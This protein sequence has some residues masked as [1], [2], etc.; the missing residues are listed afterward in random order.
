[1]ADGAIESANIVGYQDIVVP[2]GYS[3]FTVTFKKTSAAAYSYD[4]KDIQVLNSA[5]EVM[6]DDNSTTPTRRSRNKVI[7]QKMNPTTGGLYGD[8]SYKF[9]TQ[10]SKGWCDGS[11]PLGDGELTFQDGEGFAVTCPQGDSIKFR[12]SGEVVLT[13]ISMAIPNGYSI[14]G[15]M[16]PNTVDVKDIKVL[17]SAGIEMNDDSS[18]T[19][20]QRSRNKIIIQKMNPT[21]GGLYGD[22]SY[23]FNTQSNKGWCDGSTPLNAGDL[24]LAP[25]ETVAV[26]STQGDT[27]YFKFPSPISE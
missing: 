3:M 10:S 27:V 5:G 13:P 17:N 16:T 14:I 18:T 6:N 22:H 26:T 20:S 1:M 19:P 23:K 4:V 21:T 9:N 12:V 25:G 7:L 15:N 24:M 11:T 2:N 8:H